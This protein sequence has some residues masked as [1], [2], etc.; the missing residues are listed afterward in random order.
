MLLREDHGKQLEGAD[1]TCNAR[2]AIRRFR[3]GGNSTLRSRRSCI[4]SRCSRLVNLQLDHL[5]DVC[6][7][8]PQNDDTGLVQ[9]CRFSSNTSESPTTYDIA[10]YP[11]PIPLQCLNKPQNLKLYTNAGP[12]PKSRRGKINA[13][14]CALLLNQGT[15]SIAGEQ[16]MLSAR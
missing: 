8:V 13:V 9:L 12:P 7:P 14:P 10:Q 1:A 11:G 5:K 16:S 4:L 15:A 3:Y 6:Y 2:G